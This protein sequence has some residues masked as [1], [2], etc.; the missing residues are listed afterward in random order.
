MTYNVEYIRRF[1][2]GTT[3]MEISKTDFSNLE[4]LIP[5]LSE[6]RRIA[7]ILSSIDAKIGSEEKVLEKYKKIKKGLMERLLKEE[8]V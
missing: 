4:F 7:S 2:Q 5:D 6:Q 3:F 8:E 1:G